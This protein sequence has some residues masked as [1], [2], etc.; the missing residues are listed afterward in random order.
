MLRFL[1]NKY[2]FLNVSMPMTKCLWIN[3]EFGT[4]LW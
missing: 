1:Q 2:K 3:V 4:G